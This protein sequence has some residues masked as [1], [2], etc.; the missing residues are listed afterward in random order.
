[1]SYDSNYIDVENALKR[2]GG[3][4]VLYKKLLKLFV[5][6]S[7]YDALCENIE[8]GNNEEIARLAHTVKG[9][10][11]NLALTSLNEQVA[12]V[13]MEAKAGNDSKALLPGLKETFDKTLELITDY[14]G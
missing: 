3:N 4:E 11:A 12:K 9:V 7:N 10:S 6:E 8:S 5:A 2:V 14:I 1:M 13:E